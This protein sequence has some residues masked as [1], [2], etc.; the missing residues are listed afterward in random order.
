VK[1]H[2]SLISAGTEKATIEISRKSLVGKAKA[3]P[4]LVKKVIATAKKTGLKKTF[5]LVMNRLDTPVPLGY[6]LSGVVEQISGEVPGIQA[7]DRVACAGAG[8]ACHAEMASVPKN[9]I[10]K[11]PNE[12]SM[13]DAACTTVGSI[14]M[15]GI[16]QANVGLGDRVGVI[17]LGLVGQITITLLKSL[18]CRI[19]GVDLDPFTVDKAEAIGADL[20]LLRNDPG[21]Q[22]KIAEA[23]AE[24]GLDAVI[25]TAG[26]SSNDPF[27]LASEIIRDRGTLVIVG[28]IRMEIVKSVSSI[29]YMKEIDI[30]FSRSYGPGRYDRDYEEKGF[31]YP[32]GYVR[33]TENRNMK[34]FLEMLAAK[35]INLERII[36]HTF[37]FEDALKAYALIEGKSNEPFLGVLLEYS[38]QPKEEP[39]RIYLRPEAKP[40]EGKIGVGMIGAGNF[41]R[42]NLLPYLSRDPNITLRGL[43]DLKSINAKSTAGKNGFSFCAS[44]SDEILEDKDTTAIFIATRHDSHAKYVIQALKQGKHVYVEKPLS[45]NREELDGI[46]A[47]YN[48]AANKGNI[49]LMVGYNRRFA[50]LSLYLR[51]YCEGIKGPKTVI[52]RINAGYI[53]PDNW[54]Q[55]PVQGGRFIGEGCHFI[56]FGQFLTGAVPDR[57]STSGIIKSG[58]PLFQNDNLI[59]TLNMVDCSIVTVI[60]NA[61]GDSAMPKERVEVFGQ[62]SSAVLDDFKSLQIYQNGRKKSYKNR[63]Q[64]KGHKNEISTYLRLIKEEGRSPIPF[65]S[66]VQTSLATFTTIES[67]ATK[68]QIAIK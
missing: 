19:V 51:K 57:V 8:F 37:L 12:V 68:S 67:L 55:D 33:W 65:E 10:V 3:R 29:F 63:A 16:R 17:G 25:I 43:L 66:L 47:A 42:A 41:A 52:I 32:I 30:K 2:Y 48:S 26:T 20:A 50:P 38:Q 5:E 60:Y 46:I 13:Q 31:D 61:S 11:V 44:S 27:E 54:Y 9:L 21:L 4:D 7:G 23:T 56:D 1:T 14:A 18:G 62:N 45:L 36:S 15:H 40:A 22:E 64:D 24:L 39:S 28:G 49:S 34:C 59:V 6:S 53:S 58:Q 35:K